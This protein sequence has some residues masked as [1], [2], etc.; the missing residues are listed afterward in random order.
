MSE[1]SKSALSL[2]GLQFAD[3]QAAIKVNTIFVNLRV[4]SSG[5]HMFFNA[6]C[7]LQAFIA[8]RQLTGQQEKPGLH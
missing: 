4:T 5:M 1:C 3:G 6:G 2:S 7:V 8:C